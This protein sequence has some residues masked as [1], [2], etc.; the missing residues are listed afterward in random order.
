MVN[1]VDDRESLI[2]LIGFNPDSDSILIQLG[3]S[4]R[5][6][7]VSS[8]R[9]KLSRREGQLVAG[10]SA[11]QL[12]LHAKPTAG[13]AAADRGVQWAQTRYGYSNV[14]AAAGSCHRFEHLY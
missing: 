2:P 4:V 10:S 14:A 3:F 6:R 12:R 9:C 13:V 1:V 8:L 11:G 5:R 7:L